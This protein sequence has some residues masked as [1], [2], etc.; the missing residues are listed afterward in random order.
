MEVAVFG[1]IG[2]VVGALMTGGTQL[3]LERR[4]EQRDLRRAKR[5]VTGELLHAS[6]IFRNLAKLKS[7]PAFPDA[8]TMLPTSAWQENRAHL[9]GALDE[10]LWNQLVTAYSVLEIDRARLTTAK[11]ISPGTPL[12]DEVIEGMKETARDLE[13]LRRALGGSG[14]W[15]ADIGDIKKGR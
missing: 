8:S 13:R 12:T 3:F 15:L 11:D 7:W 9:A 6:L 2:V 14:G 4:R 10:D 1:L 5:L